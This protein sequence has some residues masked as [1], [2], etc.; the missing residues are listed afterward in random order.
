MA[1][2]EKHAGSLS[3]PSDSSPIHGEAEL[4][5]QPWAKRFVDSFRRDP[6]TS[7]K[8]TNDKNERVYDAK[9]AASATA[10]TSLARKLKSRHLQM[11]AIGGSIGKLSSLRVSVALDI[12]LFLFTNLFQCRHRSLCWFWKRFGEGWAGFFTYCF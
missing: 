2:T 4:T 11:I 1:D 6:R 3:A 8:D 12:S 9:A 10:E 5:K 7:Q